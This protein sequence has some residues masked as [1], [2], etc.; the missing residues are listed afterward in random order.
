VRIRPATDEDAAAA[1][2]LWT[3]AYTGRGPGGEGRQRPYAERD[4]REAVARGEALVAER[5]GEV[6][7]I[8]IHHPP[9]VP[10]RAVAE[11]DESELSRLAV[12]ES[13]KRQGAG[14]A[15]ADACAALARAAGAEAIALWSRPYQAAAHRLY[16][17]LGYARTPSRDDRDE[18][19]SRLAFVLSL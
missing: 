11:S 16:E 8:V 19:G 12:A 5:G 4:F 17:S 14:R 1:A 2:R 6:V 7:G 9:G 3:E 10:D 13:V 15:L 18:E